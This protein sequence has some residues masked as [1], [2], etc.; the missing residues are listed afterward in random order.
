MPALHEAGTR[1]RP[2]IEL[3]DSESVVLRALRAA[4]HGLLNNSPMFDVMHDILAGAGADPAVGPVDTLV[5]AV[6]CAAHRLVVVNCMHCPFLTGDEERLLAAIACHQ[7]GIGAATEA[8]L[9]P[10]VGPGHAA[11]VDLLVRHV[12]FTLAACDVVL[13]AT[14]WRLQLRHVDSSIPAPALA[15]LRLTRH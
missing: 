15:P 9:T 13:P 1:T 11:A 4:T 5:G 14:W 3:H 10:L 7:A 8:I 2:V 6:H 12:A